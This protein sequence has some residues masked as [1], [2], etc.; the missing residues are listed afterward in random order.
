MRKIILVYLLTVFVFANLA[1]FSFAHQDR[2]TEN[3]HWNPLSAGPVTTW[4]APICQKGKL[5]VQ[6]FFFYNRARG[7]FDNE[8]NYNSLA[9]DDKKYQ[10]QQQIFMQYGL[11]DRLEIDGQTVYQENYVTRNQASV[12]SA[13]LGDSYLFTRYCFIEEEDKLPHIAG[14]FQL[15]FP[16]GKYQKLDAD[17]LGTDSMGAASGGGSYDPGLG[18]NLTKKLKPFIIH[19]DAIYN[20]PQETKVD[21]VKTEY[22]KYLNYDFGIEYFLARGFNL[23]LEF[24]GFLQG[25]KTEDG[26]STPSSDINYFTIGPG[27]GWSNNKIQTLLA[28]QRTLTGTN[29][30]ANDSVVLTFVY[31]F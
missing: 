5:V 22:G 11:T 15:K 13:G 3:G 31:A 14:I 25:D 21:G 6:P 26:T 2:D 19:M 28:Y 20:L 1:D 24:N 7:A 16:T 27:I 9:G 30:D 17:K 23:M 29:T 10:Y 8:G 12:H 4:T 18:I